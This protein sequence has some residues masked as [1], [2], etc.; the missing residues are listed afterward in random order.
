MDVNLCVGCGACT[1][2]CPAKWDDGY[3][4]SLKQRTA[5]YVEYPQAVPLKY[6]INPDVCLKLTKDK[7][8]T[9]E[10]VCPAK[11]IAYGQKEAKITLDAGSIIFSPGF[12]PFDPSRFDNYQY[13][14]FAN[15]V[16]SM[17]FERIL[18]ATGPT[19]GH[20]VTFPKLPMNPKK[21]QRSEER[22]VG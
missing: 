17:E 5:I 13:T 15:V 11:A 4:S 14:N 9:C 7:C 18:S 22:R 12:K 6:A 10:E 20:V 2:K 16:T 8:G 19:M 3:N 1:E 21:K